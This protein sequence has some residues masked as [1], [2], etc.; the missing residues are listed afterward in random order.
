MK[1]KIY[2]FLFLLFNYGCDFSPPLNK[3]IL[4]A[5]SLI[6]SQKYQ[7]A[8]NKYLE[9]LDRNPSLEAKV[10]ILYQLGDLYSLY[11][12]NPTKGIFYFNEVL[13]ETDDPLWLVRTEE[14]IAEI[15]YYNLRNYEES[16]K[17]YAKLT[18]F[19][20]ELDRKDFYEFN[21]GLSLHKSNQFEEAI[22]VFQLITK[23]S[24]HSHYFESLFYLGL[25]HFQLK[26]WNNSTTFFKRYIRVGKRRDRIIESKYLL[27]NIYETT[28]KLKEAYDLYYSILGEYPNTKVLKNRLESIYERKVVRKR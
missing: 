2:F 12:N 27:A 13:R 20:P 3:K 8:I 6:S 23:S 26:D 19:R 4:E 25:S 9:V 18:N 5:Q 17:S 24:N 10:K 7:Q 14:K 21:M 11:L 16:Y 28:E 22:K 15:N 1:R